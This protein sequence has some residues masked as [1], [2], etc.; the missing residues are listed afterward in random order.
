M[1]LTELARKLRVTPNELREKLPRMG[2]DIGIKAIKIDKKIAKKIL[3]SW[4]KLSRQLEI[5]DARVKEEKL[6]ELKLEKREIIIPNFITINE[7]SRISGVLVSSI[8]KELM[9]NGIFASLNEKIDFETANIIGE[10]LGLD[11]KLDKNKHQDEEKKDDTLNEALEKEDKNKLLERPPVVVI[12][13]HVDHG[14]TKL[15]DTIRNENVIDSESGGI[16]Q[17][18]GAYQAIKDGR[19]ITFID[20]PGHEAFTAMRSRGAKIADVAILIIA[21]DDGVKPQTIEAYKIIKAAK[22]PFLI[23]INKIDKSDADINKT[24]QEISSKLN[25]TPEDWG[26]KTICLPISAQTGDG[27]QDMLNTILL[28]ADTECNSMKAN[29]NSPAIGT[30]IESHVDKSAG[31]TATILV[32]NGTLNIGDRLCFQNYIY[33]KIK[34][35]ED[36]TGKNINKAIPSTPV[37]ITGLKIAPTVG[38]I[39]SVNNDKKVKLKTKKTKKSTSQSTQDQQQTTAKND[40]DVKKINI[41]V[42]SDVLGSA[43][44]IEESLAKIDAKNIKIKIIHKGLGNIRESDIQLAESSNA[45]II[46]FN[47]KISTQIEAKLKETK[48]TAKIFK[49]IYHLTEYMQNEMKKL[50]LTNIEKENLGKLQVL[51][52]FRTEKNN[53]I[54]GGKVI[55]GLI[56]G[57]TKVEIVRNNQI[58]DYGEIS[59]IKIG[60]V[61]VDVVKQNEECGLKYKG[62]TEIQE[63]DILNIYIEKEVKETLN[64]E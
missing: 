63:N 54:L 62:S 1:N 42:K 24:K 35:L 43:E 53:Q 25:V 17:H 31:I 6:K 20:T 36:H 3:E 8:L 55:E 26:G 2:F 40:K 50:L 13:G 32:Q 7:L 56:K 37:Q 19:K 46:G 4:Y 58:I 47:V 51:K 59:E 14:K 39:L 38:D 21:A 9:K 57:N 45:Q 48:V 33:G 34:K 18:I 49:V 28:I 22:I 10:D 16:T 44:A 5:E 23:A 11:V 12:M 64:D 61:V 60:Q 15:L 27:I 30:I 52:I 29:P 41:I